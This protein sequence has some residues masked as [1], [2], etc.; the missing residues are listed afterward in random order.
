MLSQFESVGGYE[1]LGSTNVFVA[2]VAKPCDHICQH[3]KI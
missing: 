2:N 1:I 3:P